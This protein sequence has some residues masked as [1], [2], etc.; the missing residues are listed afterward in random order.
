MTL[1]IPDASD[2]PGIARLARSSFLVPRG[3]YRHRCNRCHYDPAWLASHRHLRLS[4]ILCEG[5]NG[6]LCGYA[7]Y[8]LRP[9]GDVYLKELAANPPDRSNKVRSTGTLLLQYVLAKALD[10]GCRGRAT[11]NVLA[12]QRATG[13]RRETS[14]NRD[15][16]GFYTRFGFADLDEA[17][18]TVTGDR[19][20][21]E[22]TWL[23]AD[24]QEA[25]HLTLMYLAKL[26]PGPP[27]SGPS[28]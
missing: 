1:R 10:E 7:Y 12:E 4:V 13:S 14:L 26:Q 28:P 18:Y 15:P 3:W 8:Q 16:F 17:G 21:P 24:L 19:R 22:D 5:P 9:D 11:A 20:H 23:A 25:Y 27:T 6:R 2:F